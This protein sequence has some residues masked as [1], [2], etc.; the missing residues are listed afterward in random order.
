MD[1]FHENIR[2]ARISRGLSQIEAADKMG[3]DRSTFN[4][5]ERGKTRLFSDNMELFAEAVGMTAEEILLGDN[6]VGYLREGSLEDQIRDISSKIDLL[7]VQLEQI[8]SAIR[9]NSARPASKK[10]ED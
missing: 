1:K 2:R 7:S 4:K 3:I 8:S 5:F 6:P 9:K 10:D